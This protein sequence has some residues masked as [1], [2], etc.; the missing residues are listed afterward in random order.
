[1]V[2]ELADMSLVQ[3]GAHIG[4][5]VCES[6]TGS[7]VDVIDPANTEVI[8]SVPE[9]NG[10]DTR[11]AILAADVALDAWKTTTAASRSERLQAWHTHVIES[12]EDIARLITA[13]SGKPIAESRGEVEYLSLIHI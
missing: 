6:V 1:M 10:D 3:S 11:Q 9:M 12:K 8:G 4:G 2:L 13:E 7:C 5:K